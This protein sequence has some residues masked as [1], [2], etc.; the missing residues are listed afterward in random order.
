MVP[1]HFPVFTFLFPMG[2]DKVP[3]IQKVELGFRLLQLMSFN[4]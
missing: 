1:A 4:Y 3:L 2:R